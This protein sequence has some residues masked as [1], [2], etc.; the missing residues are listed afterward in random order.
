MTDRRVFFAVALP[1]FFFGLVCGG[2]IVMSHRKSPTEL[3]EMLPEFR[4]EVDQMFANFKA[5]RVAYTV[6]L[7]LLGR[8]ITATVVSQQR[9]VDYGFVPMSEMGA[10]PTHFL[11]YKSGEFGI[12]EYN[13][14]YMFVTIRSRYVSDLM[15][16]PAESK[17]S[18]RAGTEE[19]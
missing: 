8:P 18:E 11:Y 14:D 17:F 3:G 13:N 4:Q 9:N 16:N 15:R 5:G 10:K 7:P 12:H 1:M 6:S 19:K 2:G